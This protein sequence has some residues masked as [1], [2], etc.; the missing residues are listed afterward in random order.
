MLCCSLAVFL[1]TFQEVMLRNLIGV[2]VVFRGTKHFVNSIALVS[3]VVQCT[4]LKG[5]GAVRRS[6]GLTAKL[7]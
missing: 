3:D 6:Y 1:E 7:R 4:L 5:E 2:N